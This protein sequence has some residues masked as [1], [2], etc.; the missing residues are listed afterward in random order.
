M[1]TMAGRPPN[2]FTQL[3][4]GTACLVATNAVPGAAAHAAHA[5]LARWASQAPAEAC[6]MGGSLRPDGACACFPTYTGPRCAQL[7]LLPAHGQPVH[8]AL[9]SVAS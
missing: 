6:N 4:L 7:A 9:P 5:A 2:C 8:L 3:V 1:S